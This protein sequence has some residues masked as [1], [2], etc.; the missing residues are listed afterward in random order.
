M[1]NANS[2]THIAFSDESHWNE[3]RYR[4]IAAL[5]MSK[6]H[7]EKLEADLLD[8]YRES[9]I[10]EFRWKDIKGA[11]ERFVAIKICDFAIDKTLNNML[12]VDV[13]SWDIHDSR[14]N[15]PQRDDVKNLH[16]MYRFLFQNI[17][18]SRWPKG[19]RWE[20]SP[21]EHT[22]ID[23]SHIKALLEWNKEELKTH[24]DL[25]TQKRH[26]FSLKE[27]FNIDKVNPH[28]SSD[29]PFIQLADLFAGMCCFSRL[30]FKECLLCENKMSKQLELELFD[31]KKKNIKL[32]R[33]INE[34]SLILNHFYR[35]CKSKKMGISF[36]T[37]KGLKTFNP[38]NPINFWW[39]EPQ[40][41]DDK[42]PIRK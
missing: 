12:R 24:K 29:R 16:R 41:K 23:W 2:V 7:V 15:I 26:L 17:L 3:K 20:L 9:G 18:S 30:H 4:S 36:R 35:K 5:T 19:S 37:C 32:S 38:Q 10:S 25:F 39:Y 28:K 27:R 33:P 11:R 6:N 1:N 21:H 14:H 22:A 8:I 31:N 34:K 13:V 42:A 40:R